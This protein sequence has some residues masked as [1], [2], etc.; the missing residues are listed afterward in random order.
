MYV[1]F[2]KILATL[3]LLVLGATLGIIGVKKYDSFKAPKQTIT[4][5]GSA[6]VDAQ[7]DQA[8]ISVQVKN[9]A[10]TQ[11]L[12]QTANKKDV[13]SLKKKLLELGI[14]ET[15]ITQSSYSPIVY[16]ESASS[17]VSGMMPYR[18]PTGTST[19]TVITTLTIALDSV[20][21]VDKVIASISENPNTQIQ[22]TYYSLG[23]RKEWEKKAKEEALK[24]AREQ[25]EQIAKTNKLKVGKLVSL[26]DMDQVGLYPVTME[27]RM[28]EPDYSN[29]LG[30][31]A[32]QAEEPTRSGAVEDNM[33]YGEQTVKITASYQAIYELY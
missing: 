25:I 23:H 24:D 21:N 20:K 12:A 19:P 16:R 7:T 22:N 5:I 14:P 10:A 31:E 4:V 32:P 28:I 18:P 8:N 13:D 26:K 11:E 6:E 15:R 17:D 27:K 30:M 1:D 29:D 2:K 33:F 3:A 9:T